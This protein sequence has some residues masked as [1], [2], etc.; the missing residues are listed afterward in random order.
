MPRKLL[1]LAIGNVTLAVIGG[2]LLVT[3]AEGSK[4]FAGGSHPT[5]DVGDTWFCAPEFQ[6]GVCDTTIPA[7]DTVTWNFSGAG[8]PHSSR[9]CGTSCNAATMNPL[10]NSGF[11]TD[12]STFQF[13]FDQAGTYLYRCEVHPIAMR[14]RIIVT[15]LSEETPAVTPTPVVTPAARP[16]DVDCGGTVNSIDA[17]LVLQFSAGLLHSL[18]CP[19]NGD[20]NG[21]GHINSIDAALILQHVAGLI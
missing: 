11:I 20:M 5:I 7:G 18:S 13:T 6:N 10:W 2:V 21:D 12:G 15:E 14:G 8:V 19:L 4:V 16:G 3:L 9:E 1:A 17:A